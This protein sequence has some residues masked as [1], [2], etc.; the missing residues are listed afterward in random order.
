MGVGK[1]SGKKTIAYIMYIVYICI[2]YSHVWFGLCDV[3]EINGIIAN[4]TELFSALLWVNFPLG[5]IR[6]EVVFL[7]YTFKSIQL[8]KSI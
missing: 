6:M 2:C 1:E 5:Q 7:T 8:N 4:N 3:V